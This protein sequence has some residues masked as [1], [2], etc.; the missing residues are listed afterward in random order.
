MKRINSNDIAKLAGVSRST[1]SRVINNYANVPEETRKRV[2]KV[3][4]EQNYFPQLS[5]QLL[6]GMPTRTIGLFWLSRSA[7][8]QDSLASSFFLNVIDA[9]AARDYLVLSCVVEDLNQK[10]HADS[11]RKMFMQGRIDAGIFI[12][13][14]MTEPLIEELV[15]L[16][17]VVG[18]FDYSPE[19]TGRPN[20]ITVNFDMHTGERAVDCL[21]K[22]GHRKIAIIDGD[23]SR[24]S[25]VNRHESYMRG[26][27]RHGLQLKNDWL[28][29]GG[30]TRD[31]G[32]QAARRLLQG[33]KGEYPT[34]ICANNDSVAFGVYQAC[35]EMGLRIPQDISVIGHDGHA[36]GAYSAPSLTTFSFDFG[37]MFDSLV[38]R[39][40]DAVEQRP[41]TVRDE[42]FEGTLL[43]RDSVLDLHLVRTRQ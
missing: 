16:G 10:P 15:K 18:L 17:K 20:L 42:F 1:V 13:A 23:M 24:F 30:I 4:R 41:L 36:H 34:A 39:L 14:S 22:R 6:T 27:V 19:E 5:G 40:I 31:S 2:M 35:A 32:Y 26:M 28:T 33:C 25:S 37:H 3:I 7:I 12:G 43:E 38:S 8:A 11:V 9:A 29:Y 21:Y